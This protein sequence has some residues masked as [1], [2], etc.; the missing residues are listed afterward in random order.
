LYLNTFLNIPGYL[1]W[2]V[3]NNW[4]QNKK[5]HVACFPLPLMIF[6]FLEIGCHHMSIG[7]V[8]LR[9][10]RQFPFQKPSSLCLSHLCACAQYSHCLMRK[11]GWCP[12]LKSLCFP[13]SNP[14][15]CGS[16]HECNKKRLNIEGPPIL[17]F[18]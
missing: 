13:A 17:Y 9:D 11:N 7:L 8:S 18:Y 2:K 16:V 15:D 10:I 5:L 4:K 1:R 14:V 12:L 3:A 6:P